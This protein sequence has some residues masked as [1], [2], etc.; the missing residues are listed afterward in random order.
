VTEAAS[1]A[2]GL[3]RISVVDA[4]CCVYFCAAGKS[5]LLVAIL[6]ALGLEILIA[7]EV[8]RKSSANARSGNSLSTGH[9]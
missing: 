1:G 3:R 9:G 8:E 7:E 6:T 2:G 5:G 4:V